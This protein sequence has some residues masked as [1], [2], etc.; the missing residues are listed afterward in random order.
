MHVALGY[1]VSVEASLGFSPY[2]LLY[3]TRAILPSAIK[4]HFQQPTMSR[5]RS[6]CISRLAC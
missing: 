2:E 6:T 3:G 5:P 4:E 1:R